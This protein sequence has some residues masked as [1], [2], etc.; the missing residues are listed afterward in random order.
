MKFQVNRFSIALLVTLIVYSCGAIGILVGDK[1]KFIDS[2]PLILLLTTA[3]LI[4]TAPG[5]DVKFGIFIAVIFLGGFLVEVIGANT[6]FLFGQYSYGKSMGP[7]VFKVPVIIGLNWFSI[8]YCAGVVVDKMQQLI[9]AK[10]DIPGGLTTELQLVSFVIDGALLATFFDYIMEPAAAKLGYW[11]WE[12]NSGAPFS[13]FIT[14][15]VVSALMLAFM[16]KLRVNT[17]N[18]FAVHLLIIQILFFS[19][20]R[21]FL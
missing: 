17:S 20:L 1:Q 9:E 15:F 16:R 18:H 2:T 6:G 12:G 13:N 4:W 19:I 5:K 21:S 10:V 14:W 8:I 7:L 11:E 3:L